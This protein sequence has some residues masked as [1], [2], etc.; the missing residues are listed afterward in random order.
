MNRKETDIF[1]LSD[2]NRARGNGF[3]LKEGNL[4]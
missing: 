1:T 2:S 4:G 3:K